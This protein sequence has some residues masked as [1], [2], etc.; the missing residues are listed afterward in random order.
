MIVGRNF[1][2]VLNPKAASTSISTALR[3]RGVHTHWRHEPLT[4]KPPHPIVA[5]VWRDPEDRL[6]S[7][8]KGGIPFETWRSQSGDWNAYG[9]IDIRDVDQE[10]W[11]KHVN[12]RLDFSRLHEDWQRFCEMAGLG[13]IDLPHL[14]K[15]LPHGI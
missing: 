8:W 15:G 10:H 11:F 4:S 6:R 14:N 1:V 7:A 2:F 9:G 3:G 13:H 5:A 12:F